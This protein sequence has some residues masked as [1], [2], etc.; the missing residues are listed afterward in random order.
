MDPFSWG[1]IATYVAT[2]VSSYVLNQAL[3]PKGK[4]NQP[5]AAT[6]DDWNMPMPDEGSPSVSFLETA[7]QQTGLFSVMETI[8]TRR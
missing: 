1:A 8:V 5:Q 3:A 7:G 4:N 2:L 6:E